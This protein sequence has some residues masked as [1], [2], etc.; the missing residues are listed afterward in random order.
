MVS[1]ARVDRA[2]SEPT[3]EPRA[4]GRDLLRVFQHPRAIHRRP[5]RAGARR[6]LVFESRLGPHAYRHRDRLGRRR[7]ARHPLRRGLRHWQRHQTHPDR[8]ARHYAVCAQL[9]ARTWRDGAGAARRPAQGR[10]EG[11][12]KLHV[13]VPR[14]RQG[15]QKVRRG[16]LQVFRA[17]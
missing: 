14:Y 10:R 7:D 9:D 5:G 8:R 17:V 11:Q 1:L 2:S 12:G 15:V 3:R 6:I 16:A 4:N 13:R